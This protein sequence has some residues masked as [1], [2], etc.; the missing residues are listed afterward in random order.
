VSFASYTAARASEAAPEASASDV[1]DALA[2][3]RVAAQEDTRGDADSSGAYDVVWWDP[4]SL[5]L[6]RA[7]NYGLRREELIA[8]DAPPAVIAEGQGRYY[9]WRANREGALE[10][11]ATPSQRIVTVRARA[12]T[13]AEG[14][15]GEHE[16]EHAPA[17]EPQEVLPPV[18]I[19]DVR[20]NE[21]GGQRP[22]GVRFGALVHAVL[23]LV[24]LDAGDEA[25]RRLAVQQARVLGASAAE[26]DACVPAVLAALRHPLFDRARA[27]RARGRLRRETPLAFLDTRHA[28]VE[29]VIDLAFE[30]DAGWVVVDFKTDH[31]LAGVPLDTYRRQVALY[32]AGISRATGRPATGILLRL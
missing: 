11:G 10:R 7:P 2:S 14:E 9:T 31:E 26:R 12:A 27:A 16:P 8:K 28:I 4:A 3:G 15:E 18:E 30:E 1:A 29:G 13:V 23:A 22:S 32:A 21:G 20:A 5:E 6:D 19:V 25:V 24:P 17:S